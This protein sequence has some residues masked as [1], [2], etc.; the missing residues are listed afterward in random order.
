[1][2]KLLISAAALITLLVVTDA[3][4]ATGAS[5]FAPGRHV[6]H[7]KHGASAHAPGHL[8]LSKGPVPGHPG[9]S[10]YAPGRHV[11]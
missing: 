3:A 9:A 1:M 4:F 5:R 11:H 7:G 10:G 2:T 6:I 8:F